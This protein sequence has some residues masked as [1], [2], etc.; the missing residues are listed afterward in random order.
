MKDKKKSWKTTLVG[1][2]AFVL[3]LSCIALLVFDKV[4]LTEFSAITGSIT[5]FAVWINGY[6]SKDKD[7][8]HSDYYETKKP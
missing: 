1:T 5:V 6:L 7:A 4:D 2:I 3:Y 8:T